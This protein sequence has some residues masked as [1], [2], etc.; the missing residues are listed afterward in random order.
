MRQNRFGLSVAFSRPFTEDR[1]IDLRRLVAPARQSLA[2]QAEF[3][4][5]GAAID[6]IRGKRAA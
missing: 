2:D 4:K 5:R 3:R 1:A 6:A